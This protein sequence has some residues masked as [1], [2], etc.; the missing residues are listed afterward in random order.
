MYKGVS[1]DK[2]AGKWK[3]YIRDHNKL[4][5][6]GRYDNEREAAAV[7]NAT[8]TRIFGVFAKPNVFED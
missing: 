7:Y 5:H 8:A 3:S 1:W 6:L 4:I 2:D